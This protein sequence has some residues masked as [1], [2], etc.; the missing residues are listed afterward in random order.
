MGTAGMAVPVFICVSASVVWSVPRWK[1]FD[2]PSL[3]DIR[4][5]NGVASLACDPASIN[6][7]KKM[8]ARD[9]PRRTSSWMIQAGR[10]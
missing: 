3:P 5:K 9:E 7:R 2:Y 1:R 4:S 8:D 10:L 6:F